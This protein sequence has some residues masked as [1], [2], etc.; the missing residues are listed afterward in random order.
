[1]KKL[2]NL[3]KSLTHFTLKFMILN[4]ILSIFFLV[5]GKN[6]LFRIIKTNYFLIMGNE[7]LTK[8]KKENRF[9]NNKLFYLNKLILNKV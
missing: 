4:F 1:M 3:F 2:F 7:I 9:L 5:I 6:L 8:N